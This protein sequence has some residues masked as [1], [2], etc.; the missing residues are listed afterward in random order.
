MFYA[1]I[2]CWH[3]LVGDLVWLNAGVSPTGAC[4][5]QA[6]RRETSVGTCA[7]CVDAN[8]A[9]RCVTQPARRILPWRDE[10]RSFPH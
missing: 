5:C 8:P 3:N 9:T 4:S 2:F 7:T 10:L 1:T 6:N